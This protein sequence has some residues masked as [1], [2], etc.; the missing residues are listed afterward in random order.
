MFGGGISNGNLLKAEYE[1]SASLMRK[2]GIG[3]L[4]EAMSFTSVDTSPYFPSSLLH[5]NVSLPLLSGALEVLSHKNSTLIL[6]SVILA[7][8]PTQ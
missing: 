5:L 6:V 1:G 7:A 3:C 8:Y 2:T 4:Y